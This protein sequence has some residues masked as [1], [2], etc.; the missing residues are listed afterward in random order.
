M[1]ARLMGTGLLLTVPTGF[2]LVRRAACGT[3]A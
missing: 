3:A 1:I 2:V